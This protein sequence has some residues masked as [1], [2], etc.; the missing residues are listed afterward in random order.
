[1]WNRLII[2]WFPRHLIFNLFK[3]R[4]NHHLPPHPDNFHFLPPISFISHTSLIITILM[5]LFLSG[6]RALY[7]VKFN[8]R[9]IRHK[10]DGKKWEIVSSQFPKWVGFICPKYQQWK[11]WLFELGFNNVVWCEM[12]KYLSYCHI[13]ISLVYY[14]TKYSSFLWKQMTK[15]AERWPKC[16]KRHS[17]SRPFLIHLERENYASKY[18]QLM[19]K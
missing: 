9:I 4:V 14:Q 2:G 13:I 1:M 16:V 18:K 7:Y 5:Y 6:L 12:C 17:S 19:S 8:I 10:L 3:W 15:V 11:S